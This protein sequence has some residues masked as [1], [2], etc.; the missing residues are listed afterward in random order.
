MP[1]YSSHSKQKTAALRL[2]PLANIL[3]VFYIKPVVLIFLNSVQL[4]HKYVIIVVYS[5][6]IYKQKQI[7]S[8][9]DLQSFSNRAPNFVNFYIALRNVSTTLSFRISLLYIPVVFNRTIRCL[10]KD[11]RHQ[12]F[13][14]LFIR[15]SF[16]II[17]C[18]LVVIYLLMSRYVDL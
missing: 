1:L 9:W 6:A 2:F 4:L 13:L 3:T 17:Y 12:V 11:N 8:I 15:V 10:F 14:Y 18:K 16:S 5:L 7:I